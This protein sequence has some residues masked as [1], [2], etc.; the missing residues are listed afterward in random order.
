MGWYG[1]ALVDVLDY[2]PERH[3]YRDSLIG[4]LNRFANAIA[5]V[6]DRNTGLWYDILDKPDEAKNYFEASASSMFVYT[7]AKGV[8]KG[9]LP[10]SFARI[11][12]QGYTGIRNKFI[13]VVDGRYQLSGTVSV[14]GL[15]GK[16]YRDGSFNYYMSEPVVDNDPK[17]MGA[18]I[19]A[20]VEMETRRDY[21]MGKDQVVL[22][23]RYFNNEWKRN[24]LGRQERFHYTWEDKTNSGFSMLGTVFTRYGADTASLDS[25]PTAA[26][27]QKASVYII[28]DPD[29]EKETSDLHQVSVEDIDAITAWVHQGGILLLM[30][31]DAGNANLKGLNLL[32]SAFG[33]H[34]NEDNF[35]RV[36]QNQFQQGAV[37]ATKGELFTQ[38]RTLYIKELATLSVS[39]PARVVVTK[40]NRN[41]IA[42]APFGKGMVLAIGDPWL[43]NEYLDGRKLPEEFDNY[44]AATDLVR[45]CLQKRK[46]K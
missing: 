5:K 19:Q 4:I 27:L 45:W 23:D 33:I 2:F 24:D 46:D 22:L 34:F 25:A 7:L 43:Y 30:G 17:G 41:I 18:F 3:P 37:A 21:G 38:P 32:S 35:N 39:A 28:V 26:G 14:S 12:Q 8:R 44:G 6:Q 29:T 31:N 40:D 36:E 20:A 13:S 15:G 1:M 16:P 11:A 42:I 10:S 9:Y